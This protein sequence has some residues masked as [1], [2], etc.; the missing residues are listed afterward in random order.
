MALITIEKVTINIPPDADNSKLDLIILK[1]N[2]IMTKQER[3]DAILSR[4]DAVTN[5][6][7]GDF[8]AFVEEARTGTVSDESFTK[9]EENIAK[10]EALAAS[11]TQPIP[12]EE[13][14]PADGSDTTSHTG[15]DGSE[16]GGT[17]T[18]TESGAPV[19]NTTGNPAPTGQPSPNE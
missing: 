8:A 4:I 18:T 5:D 7:A 6:L 14:P 13:T 9:A 10:L 19:E 3:F 1:L 17:T 11:K 2:Q 12:G 16:T 15:T